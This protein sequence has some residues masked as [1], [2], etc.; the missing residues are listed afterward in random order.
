MTVAILSPIHGAERPSPGSMATH[1]VREMASP[2]GFE[3]ST[4]R[5]EGGCSV[6]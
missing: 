3:P 6:R 2:E 1:F 5:L 4:Y